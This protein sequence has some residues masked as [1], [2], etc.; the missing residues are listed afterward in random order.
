MKNGI[1]TTI[2]NTPLVPLRQITRE[3]K[4]HVYAKWEGMNPGGSAKDRPALRMIQEGLRSGEIGPD[5]VIIESSSGNMA[6]SLAMICSYLGLRLICVIDPKTTTQNV[7]IM[8][9]YGAEIDWVEQPDPQTGEFLPARIARV[10]AL[11]SQIENSYWPNQYANPHNYLSHYHTTMKEI[12]ASLKEIDYLFCGVSSCG[13]IRGCAEYIK[14]HKLKTKVIAVDAKGSMIFGGE[15]SKR[16]FPGLGAGMVPPQLKP[17]LIDRTVYVTDLDCVIGCRLLLQKESILAGAS[18]G[19]VMMGFQSI[20]AELPKDSTSVLIF[21]DR[22][23]RYLD[24][25]YSREWVKEHV[26]AMPDELQ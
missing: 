5:T 14:D 19:G 15:K 17:E 3:P 12:A 4:Q 21:P 22:G 23:D 24:T 10:Q 18:S 2:G 7:Q 13:T 25:V 8:K 26:G 20:S 9:A 11:L 6:I 16:L 1:L